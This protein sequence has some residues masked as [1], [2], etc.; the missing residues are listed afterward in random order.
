MKKR[1]NNPATLLKFLAIKILLLA[2]VSVIFGLP[3]QAQDEPPIPVDPTPL[4][5][6]LAPAE[7]TMIDKENSA[8][9]LVEIYL[10]ISDAHLNLAYNA[11]MGE[12]YEDSL[13]EL[14]IYNKAL[15]A[16]KERAFSQSGEKRK[17]AKKVEQAILKQLRTLDLIE[18]YSTREILPFSQVAVKHAKQIRADALNA[19][20]DAGEVITDPEK[21]KPKKPS[22]SGAFFFF[23][24]MRVEGNFAHRQGAMNRDYLI[25]A[26]QLANDYLTEEEDGYVREAQQPDLRMKVFMKIADRRLNAITKPPMTTDD[27]KAQK[28]AEEEERKWGKLPERTRA[29]YLNDYARTVDEAMAKLDDAYERNPKASFVVKALKVL[30]DATEE[31]LKMLH[32]LEAEMKNDKEKEALGDAI[33]KAELAI[34][35]ANEGLKKAGS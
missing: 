17:L 31:H 11:V 10:K 14:D 29:G 20:F 21:N 19:S 32:N 12:K 18:R 34:K 24:P 27:K 25:N 9:K 15:D 30:R 7:K 3:A 22:D 4:A 1:L 28:Q 26:T 5:Q 2:L 33:E 8:K 13:R 35:G 16:A 23:S 6:L